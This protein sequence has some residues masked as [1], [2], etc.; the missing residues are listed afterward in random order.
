V[1]RDATASRRHCD[2][3]TLLRAVTA[4]VANL[5]RHV[6]EVDALNVFPVPDGD[7]GSN[8]LATMRAALAET[9]ALAEDQRSLENVS[10][11]L[12]F[13]A[14]MGAR[15][16]SGVILSQILRGM[17]DAA[18][19]RRRANGL[20]LAYALQRGA[21]K[22]YAA[23]IR[24]VEGTIL[25][26]M[27]DASSG[28]VQAAER[29][30]SVESVL[31]AAVSSAEVAVERT[32]SLLPVLRD[33]GVVDSGG[34]G[35][36]LLLRGMLLDLATEPGIEVI[37]TSHAADIAFSGAALPGHGEDEAAF[38]YETMLL[39]TANGRSLDLEAMRAHLD[40]IG[41]SVLVAGDHRA[42]RLHVHNQRPDL[43]LSYALTLGALSAITVENLDRQ[44]AAR[45][46]RNGSA[47]EASPNEEPRAAAGTPAPDDGDVVPQPPASIA[48][49]ASIA[50][51]AAPLAL[52][53]VAAGDGLARLFTRLG[54]RGVV[55]GGQAANPSTGEVLAAIREA[56][57][58]YVV[59]LPNNANVRL[60]AEQAATLA[61]GTSVAVV[62]T[63]NA[64][65]G[66][67]AALR[68][69]PAGDLAE[70][71]ERM[72]AAARELRSLQVT[73]AV[74]DARVSGQ[75]VRRGQ[76]MALDPDD[77]LVAV[78]RDRIEA[79]LR[80]LHPLAE[81]TELITA[82]YGAAVDLEE[83]QHLAT[84]IGESFPGVEVELVHGGQP[85]YAFVIAAE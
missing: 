67:A 7:T 84:R 65:E 79:V 56:A 4:G 47:I 11:A 77:G 29:D 13:G 6:A 50:S 70:N 34:Q 58:A 36:F 17:A 26:V 21:D 18:E 85:H 38:G 81:G 40:G 71:V 44:A 73:E 49:P 32:P 75:R 41:G 37:P 19:G 43:V 1:I 42:A 8:M 33:A 82:Y 31:E 45:R 27:R 52:I 48:A 39:V 69:D 2:G 22:A 25:T 14:L 74:R 64:A 20:D 10:R 83:A 30:A 16:N 51:P 62:P 78:G 9:A 53:A 55:V 61:E 60:A 57:A 59:V 15:G 23:V 12:A 66:V 63:R 46:A 3:P 76:S 24:P 80:A 54:A 35:L 72:T 68:F 5:E 28:A